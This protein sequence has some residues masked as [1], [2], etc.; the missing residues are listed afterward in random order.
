MN[1]ELLVVEECPN[2]TPAREALRRALDQ[3]GFNA[4]ISTT[5]VVGDAQARAHG[6]IGSPSFHIDGHDL[7]PVPSPR[8]G[9]AC[10]VYP[11][12]EGLRGIPDDRAFAVA[13]AGY[14][15]R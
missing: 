15:H 5:V 6:F 7:F 1:V 2:G 11:T 4:T 8:P 14:V 9:V 12:P 3:A 13:L 10:R